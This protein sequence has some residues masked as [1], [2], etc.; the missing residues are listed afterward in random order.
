[1]TIIELKSKL[2]K[3]MVSEQKRYYKKL[4]AMEPHEMLVYGNDYVTRH[5]ILDFLEENDLTESQYKALL[6]LS[7]PLAVL[8]DDIENSQALVCGKDIDKSV[9]DVTEALSQMEYLRCRLHL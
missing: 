1:M 8:A 5:E 2:L 7:T 9:N 3:R 4:I 6:K